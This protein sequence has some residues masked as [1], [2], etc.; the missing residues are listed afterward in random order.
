VTCLVPRVLRL[1]SSRPDE[2]EMIPPTQTPLA[3]QTGAPP[4]PHDDAHLGCWSFTQAAH[5]GELVRGPI[6]TGGRLTTALITLPRTDL[7]STVLY[8]PLGGELTVNPFWCVQSRQ[9]ARL[10]LAAAGRQTLGGKLLIKSNVPGGCGAGGASADVTATIRAV[11]AAIG[12]RLS[13]EQAQRMAWAV[14]GADSPLGLLPTGRAVVYGP[15]TGEA[16]RSLSRPLPPLRCLGFNAGPAGDA[17]GGGLTLCRIQYSPAEAV[18]FEGVLQRATSA[19]ERGDAAGLARAATDSARLNQ[20]RHPTRRF[21]ELLRATADA[22]AA[23]LAVSHARTAAAALFDPATPDLAARMAGLARAL[24]D[25]GC[26]DVAP[27][28]VDG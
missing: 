1:S 3:L 2:E 26:G 21:D 9:A 4:R 5:W 11:A 28:G 18:A 22:G 17:S 19:V 7:H 13:P 24:R 16:I 8:T 10:V 12:L 23:G 27:F 25:L 14:G 20:Y 15:R 6:R